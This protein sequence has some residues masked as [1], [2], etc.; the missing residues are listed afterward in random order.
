MGNIEQ[1]GGSEIK[2]LFK[3]VL[4]WLGYADIE[5]AHALDSW[6]TA[7]E[8]ARE[9]AKLCNT[10]VAKTREEEE[11]CRWANLLLRVHEGGICAAFYAIR[12]IETHDNI[13]VMHYAVR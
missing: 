5:I 3:E 11:T 13:S 9:L 6:E 12:A 1:V 10:T 7:V 2:Q 4:E 8:K